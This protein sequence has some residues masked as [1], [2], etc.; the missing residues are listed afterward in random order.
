MKRLLTTILVLF[1]FCSCKELTIKPNDCTY[2]QEEIQILVREVYG[3]AYFLG[4][5]KSALGLNAGK[6][7]SQDSLDFE[8]RFIN[9]IEQ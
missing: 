7:F 2:S 5:Q 6:T 8:N 4:A 9:K 3:Y 1:A